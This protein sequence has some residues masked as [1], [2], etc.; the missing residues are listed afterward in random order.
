VYVVV[1]R[2]TRPCDTSWA[3]V[4]SSHKPHTLATPTRTSRRKRYERTF[5]IDGRQELEV[6]LVLGAQYEERHGFPFAASLTNQPPT[7]HCEQS[8]DAKV[9]VKSSQL[10]SLDKF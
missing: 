4:G 3:L 9:S 7:P 8:S 2:R 10:L 6:L 1:C 5:F